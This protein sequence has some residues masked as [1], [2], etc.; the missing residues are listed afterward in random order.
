M[1]T[2]GTGVLLLQESPGQEVKVP[3]MS[4]E[5]SLKKKSWKGSCFCTLDHKLHHQG[6]DVTGK[7]DMSLL[8]HMTELGVE[9]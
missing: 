2:I 7:Q 6:Q 4:R 8:K 5:I 9:N 1:A 3:K